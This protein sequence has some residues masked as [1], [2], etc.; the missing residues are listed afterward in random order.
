MRR[1]ASRPSQRPSLRRSHQCDRSNPAH[2]SRPRPSGPPRRSRRIARIGGASTP[3]WSTTS[4]VRQAA[5]AATSTPADCWSASWAPPD[6]RRSTTTPRLIFLVLQE[7]AGGGE[8]LVSRGE[9]IEIGD[10]FRIPEIME[11]SGTRLR[12]GRARPTARASTTSRARSASDTRADSARTPEQLPHRRLHRAA[13][14]CD[15]LVALGRERGLP[16]IE[17]LGSGCLYDLAAARRRR[18][19][20][21]PRL[22]RRR[23]RRCRDVQRRQAAG[24]PAGGP[25]RRQAR[26][27]RAHP[28]RIRC[29]AR[30]APTS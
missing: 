24:R 27:G 10:G 15:E 26:D 5:V 14:R 25:D 13:E 29:S 22:A 7:L 2:Q 9:L 3:T 19:A 6:A 28:P 11:R 17:D 12:R 16:V 18:G 4:S 23:R 21:R 20:P 8:T 30:C 1:E